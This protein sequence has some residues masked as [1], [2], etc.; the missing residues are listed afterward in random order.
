LLPHW[1]WPGKE[2]QPIRVDALSN[3]RAVELFLNGVSLGRK[4][5]QPNS[6]LSWQVTYAPGTLSAKGYD[7]AG[8]VTA[9][10]KIETTGDASQIQLTPDRQ[11]INADGEDVSVLTV[12]ALDAQGRVVPVAMNKINFAIDGP[13]KI[14]GVGNGDPSCHEPDVFIPQ[15]PVRELPVTGWRWQ[16]G[17][18][19]ALKQEQT[20]EFSP[21]F[22]DSHWKT[23]RTQT[24]GDTGELPLKENESA[25]YRAH[26]PL[27]PEDLDN[28]SVLLQFA[29]ID[30]EGWVYV[31]G[32]RVGESHDWQ[33]TPSFNVKQALHPGDNVIAVGVRN[34]GGQGGV[35]SNVTIKIVSRPT[36]TAWSR[37]L[38][39]GL[40]QIIVQ[41]TREAGEI[42]LTA[43]G[44][45]LQ[46][47]TA[48]ISTVSGPVR[49]WQTSN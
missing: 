27:T 22:D 42:K 32:K 15:L 43:S 48:L 9:Q 40:A 21:G 26:I 4:T 38:F 12:T 37:S 14:I 5:M 41:S 13:G 10:T 2:G 31:N 20:L 34:Y 45:G 17:D 36:G 30:D 44:D 16:L 18:Y 29:S 28:P 6:K 25:Y 3:C 49:T 23:I 1:N 33:D 7:A 11:T 35:K 24:D 46:P 39:N 8:Q 19:A 47:A